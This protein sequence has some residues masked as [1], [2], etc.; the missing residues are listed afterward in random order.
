MNN[1][2]VEGDIDFFQE[3]NNNNNDDD[4]D[5]DDGNN[6][7]CL[8]TKEQLI[9]NYIT[10]SCN[11]SFNYFPLYKEVCL[12]KQKSSRLTNLEIVKLS[13][14][15]I[16]CPY[17]RTIIN[18]L[19]PYIPINHEIQKIINVNYPSKYCM[20]MYKCRYNFKLGKSKGSLCNKHAYEIPNKDGIYCE[21][22]WNHINNNNDKTNK[23]KENM[24]WTEEM[25]KLFKN[26]K[27][28]ELKI[29]LKENGHKLTGTKKELV[30]RLLN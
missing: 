22:H 4:D 1:Y 29:L 26:N 19:I 3:L 10:L 18:N 5:D 6:N 23:K 9:H 20:T 28:N 8:I 13:S 25:E 7:I 15:Q 21:K 30:Y 14:Q 16:K 17:C 12:Q 24:I 2:I 11:H 27:V